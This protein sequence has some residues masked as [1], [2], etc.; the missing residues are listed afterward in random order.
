[1]M[2]SLSSAMNKLSGELWQ[3]SAKAVF[4]NRWVATP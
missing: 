3:T 1:M 2:E 4:P